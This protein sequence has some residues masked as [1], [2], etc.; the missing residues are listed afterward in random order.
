[1][2]RSRWEG[3]QSKEKHEPGDLPLFDRI[4]PLRNKEKV[5]QIDDEVYLC[6]FMLFTAIFS[7]GEI[8]VFCFWEFTQRCKNIHW[9]AKKE[10]E[11]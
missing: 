4:D 8:A 9:K 1:M 5:W 2:L 3:S 7:M 11:R 10:E 6:F